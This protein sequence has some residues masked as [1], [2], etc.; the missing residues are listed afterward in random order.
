METVF[1]CQYIKHTGAIQ[2]LNTLVPFARFSGFMSHFPGILEW[3]NSGFIRGKYWGIFPSSNP[4]YHK[5]AFARVAL[6]LR[7]NTF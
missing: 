3:L 6:F 5:E 1:W 7:G 2:V 4:L